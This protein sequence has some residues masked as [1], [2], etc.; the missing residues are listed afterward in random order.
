MDSRGVAPYYG[1]GCTWTVG[2]E[3]RKVDSRLRCKRAAGVAHVGSLHGTHG[4][5]D[6]VSDLLPHGRVPA[7]LRKPCDLHEG[8]GFCARA[9]SSQ[10][11]AR[12][13]DGVKHADRNNLTKNGMS[14]TLRCE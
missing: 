5:Q 1:H 7:R 14:N 12:E 2:Y 9:S 11:R 6:R 13:F 4:F 10:E 3:R 8:H